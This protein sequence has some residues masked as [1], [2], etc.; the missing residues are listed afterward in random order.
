MDRKAFIHQ[1]IRGT[2]LLSFGAMVAFFY[3]NGKITANE[4]CN[5]DTPCSNCKELQK[6]PLPQAL[7]QRNHD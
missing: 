4:A 7:K 5:L 2:I 1:L 3:R 6:C